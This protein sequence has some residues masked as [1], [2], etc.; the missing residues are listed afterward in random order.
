SYK[1]VVVA[2]DL[3]E[4]SVQVAR[5]VGSLG[6]LREAH[7]W[8]VHAFDVPYYGMLETRTQEYVDSFS[9]HPRYQ[10]ERTF[11][12]EL[13]DRGVDLSKVRLVVQASKPFEAIEQCLSRTRAELL[14]IGTSRWFMLKR[15][16]FGSVADE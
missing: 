6:V 14:V 16:L 1:S 3:S 11:L 2:T 7:T 5:T 10:L 13:G 9:H 12:A 8:V 4:T 15:L